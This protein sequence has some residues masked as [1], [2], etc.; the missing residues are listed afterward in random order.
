MKIPC[1]SGCSSAL[2]NWDYFRCSHEDGGFTTR[3]DSAS[4]QG[5]SV[6]YLQSNSQPRCQGEMPAAPWRLSKGV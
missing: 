5:G 2:C 4:R 1:C 3:K 6:L